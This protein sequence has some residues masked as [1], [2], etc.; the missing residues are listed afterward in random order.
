VMD[1]LLMSNIFMFMKVTPVAHNVWRH[2]AALLRAHQH[3]AV[4]RFE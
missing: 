1:E 4:G 2:N 3:G